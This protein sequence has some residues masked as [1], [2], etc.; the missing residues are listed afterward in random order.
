[1]SGTAHAVVAIMVN[2]LEAPITL[3]KGSFYWNPKGSLHGPTHAEE[4]SILLEVYD[5][6]HYPTQPEWYSAEA[7][8]R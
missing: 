7:D 4:D 3:T 1:M 5:G 8:A 6:P 2:R